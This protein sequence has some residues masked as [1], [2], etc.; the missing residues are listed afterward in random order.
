MGKGPNKAI[1]TIMAFILTTS[2]VIAGI[3]FVI[4]KESLISKGDGIAKE[5]E[6]NF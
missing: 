1:K 5:G 3:F 4:A 6:G 2:G